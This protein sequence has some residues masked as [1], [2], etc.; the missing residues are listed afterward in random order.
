[1]TESKQNGELQSSSWS[2]ESLNSPAAGIATQTLGLLLDRVKFEWNIALL[3]CI[4]CMIAYIPCKWFMDDLYV[5]FN[6]VFF[7]ENTFLTLYCP[8]Q[9]TSLLL[10]PTGGWYFFFTMKFTVCFRRCFRQYFEYCPNPSCWHFD[11][12][13]KKW[14]FGGIRKL[15]ITSTY[16]CFHGHPFYFA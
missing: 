11:C 6:A 9:A 10:Y 13:H 16:I 12:L 3:L 1:M 2:Q 7:S 5:R 8:K 14:C 15:L 4:C